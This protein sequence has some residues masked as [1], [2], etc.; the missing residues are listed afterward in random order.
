MTPHEQARRWAAEIRL[1]AKTRNLNQK[2]ISEIS[3]IHPVSVSQ[4]F[5][6]KRLPTTE[7]LAAIAQAIGVELEWVDAKTTDHATQ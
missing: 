7:T 1:I 5:K 2:R 3:G 4:I 6:G